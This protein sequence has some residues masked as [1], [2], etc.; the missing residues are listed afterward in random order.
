MDAETAIG[1]DASSLRSCYRKGVS[2]MELGRLAEALRAFECGTRIDPSNRQIEGM[3]A[4]VQSRIRDTF[5][6]GRAEDVERAKASFE[7]NLQERIF[8]ET[9][10]GEQEE[11]LRKQKRE[12]Y[13]KWR[14]RVEEQQR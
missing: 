2:L 3:V 1:L 6:E 12:E 5:R 9:L 7:T 8:V 13:D 11:R 4:Q 10:E 14:T